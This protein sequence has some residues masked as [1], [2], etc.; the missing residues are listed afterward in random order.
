MGVKISE[1]SELTSIDNNDRLIINHENQTYQG[2]LNT[3]IGN[4]LSGC[5][6]S[7]LSNVVTDSNI[8]DYLYG[9]YSMGISGYLNSYATLDDLSNYTQQI[10]LSG[11]LNDNSGIITNY[12]TGNGYITESYLTENNYIT[13]SYLSENYY[14]TESYLSENS[15]ITENYLNDNNY[16][17]HN[18]LSD[19][20]FGGSGYLSEITYDD[21]TINYEAIYQGISSYFET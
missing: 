5:L 16:I 18:N 3:I 21:G 19:H 17:N 12:L 20:L 10:N 11:Y 13:G 14:V 7:Y 1:L 4:Y 6:S 9:N 8:S 2:S 15:Y